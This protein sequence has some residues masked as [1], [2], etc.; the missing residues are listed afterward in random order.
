MISPKTLLTALTGAVILAT[1]ARADIW[2]ETDLG[3]LYWETTVDS[4]SVFQLFIESSTDLDPTFKIF[5]DG[6]S[7]L[8]TLEDLAG[9]TF[10]GIWYDYEDGTCPLAASD[11]Y[12]TVAPGWGLVTIAFDADPEYFSMV[13]KDCATHQPVQTVAGSPGQ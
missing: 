6:T 2:W 7:Q 9:R 10:G 12:G 13:L 11:P 5:V 4:Y 3:T 1:P 8:N